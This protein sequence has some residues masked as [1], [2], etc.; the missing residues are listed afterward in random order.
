MELTRSSS[1]RLP[2]A[3]RVRNILNYSNRGKEIIE[4]TEDL[5][6]DEDV[7]KML[8]VGFRQVRKKNLYQ[9]GILDSFKS[10]LYVYKDE[11]TIGVVNNREEI[12]LISPQS[13]KEIKKNG[14]SAI[15]LGVVI[16]GVLSQTRAGLRY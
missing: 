11:F 8:E 2:V 12:T 3:S 13:A 5:I 4:K 1:L 7:N 16:I 9:E 6:Q 10:S 14:Y 15:H